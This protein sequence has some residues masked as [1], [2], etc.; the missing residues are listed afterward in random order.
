M[1]STRSIGLAATGVLAIVA[2]AVIGATAGSGGG[3]SNADPSGPAV[4]TSSATTSASPSR[5]PSTTTSP[6]T[7]RT[8]SGNGATAT[9]TGGAADPGDGSSDVGAGT[10][11]LPT[12]AGDATA[13][14]YSLPPIPTTKP[15]PLLGATLPKP[16]TAKGRLVRGFPA[17]LA[18][19]R[20]TAIESSSVSV[21]SDVLQAALVA[22][23][24]DPQSI[25]QHYREL[26]AERGFAEQATQGAENAPAGAFAK[27]KGDHRNTVTVTTV[28]GKTYLIANL[29]PTDA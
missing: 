25:L 24:G 29:R 23:G 22:D 9:P 4:G 14:G 11:I 17:A 2:A 7:P 21:A 27:G 28:D 6:R 10:E 18:P 8:G 16:A 12:P 13:T 3:S 1:A 15:A 20:G 5:T 19:P 26:L